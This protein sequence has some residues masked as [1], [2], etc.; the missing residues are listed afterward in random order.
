MGRPTAIDCHDSPA[1]HGSHV[2]ALPPTRLCPD[3]LQTPGFHSEYH[4][5]EI[6]FNEHSKL[7][8]LQGVPKT[9]TKF[10]A[11]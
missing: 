2:S 10:T 1:R 5:H 7:S 4:S 3:V 9:S 6:S 8:I 11:P